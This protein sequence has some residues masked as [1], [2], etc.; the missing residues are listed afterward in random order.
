MSNVSF[1][2]DLLDLFQIFVMCCLHVISQLWLMINKLNSLCHK[3]ELVECVKAG[4]CR[5]CVCVESTLGCVQERD[6]LRDRLGSAEV[7]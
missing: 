5:L 2:I 1:I 3:F 6:N 4:E 7:I